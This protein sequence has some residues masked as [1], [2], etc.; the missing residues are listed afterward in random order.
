[1]AK[2]VITCNHCG[3]DGWIECGT[4]DE[5]GAWITRKM[6]CADCGAGHEMDIRIEN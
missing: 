5:R 2:N 6:K 1:M 3:S 4:V